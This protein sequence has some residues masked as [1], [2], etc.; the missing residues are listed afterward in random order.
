MYKEQRYCRL[1]VAPLM[2][3]VHTQRFMP[4]DVDI[5]CK[6]WNPVDLVLV[7]APVESALP[8]SDK[9]LHIR[10]GGAIVPAGTVKLVRKARELKLLLKYI[11]VG[12]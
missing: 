4:V 5:A 9:P 11:E 1:K 7:L 6:L 3:V 2:Y 8:P 12:V 10:Q